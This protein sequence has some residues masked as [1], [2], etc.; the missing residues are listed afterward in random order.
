MMIEYKFFEAAEAE[1]IKEKEQKFNDSAIKL[2]QS[3][4]PVS[5]LRN[6]PYS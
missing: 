5:S 4:L 2:K 3:T 6:K 1:R